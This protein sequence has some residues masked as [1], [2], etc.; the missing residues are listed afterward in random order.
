MAGS[1]PEA[2]SA[3]EGLFQLY[4]EGPRRA[5]CEV[6]SGRRRRLSPG[7]LEKPLS[8]AVQ[9]EPSVSVRKLERGF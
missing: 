4:G 5:C 7:C 1:A 6:G 8:L 3:L 9:T 2:L